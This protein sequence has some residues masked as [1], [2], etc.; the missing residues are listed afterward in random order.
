LLVAVLL[1]AVFWYA[2]V[3]VVGTFISRHRW[4]VFRERFACLCGKPPLDYSAMRRNLNGE[5]YFI[6]SFEAI[7]DN[8][9]L[10]IKN[11]SLTIPVLLKNAQTYISPLGGKK[12]RMTVGEKMYADAD[13]ND[14][15]AFAEAPRRLNWNRISALTAGAKVFIG[16]ALRQID[17]QTVFT[18]IKGQP[19]L[20][21]F[22]ECSEQALW[23]GI[24][25][26]G[27]YQSEYWNPITPYALI[28]G[29]FS[30]LWIAQFFFARPVYR[31]VMLSA[32]TALFGPLVPFLP[33]GLIFTLLY[34]H[35]WQRSC[36]YRVFR[37]VVV[38]PL[39][40]LASE[41]VC[42]K[43]EGQPSGEAPPR[44]IPAATPEKNETWYVSSMVNDEAE[45]GMTMK[46]SSNPFITYGLIPGSPK[47][48]S[49][50]YNRNALLFEIAAWG[51]LAVGIALNAFFAE[52]IIYFAY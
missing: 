17:G 20:V 30:L 46:V 21:I 12:R 24:L 49:R 5:Y 10:W 37:D 32:I 31:T 40:Y 2:L 9:T 35:L 6:G 29:F 41:Y 19:L 11:E 47:V 28:C 33:P 25:R 43:F 14:F 52:L 50:I 22:Y 3:P 51:I 26:A 27:R 48:I 7:T 8:T 34:R 23:A 39:K 15:D 1:I 16:G 13:T 36:L 42:R 45:Q 4:C 38:L 18:A 44:I